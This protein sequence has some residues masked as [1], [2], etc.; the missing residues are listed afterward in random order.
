M[1]GW[2]RKVALVAAVTV[3][4]AALAIVAL[5]PSGDDPSS[6]RAPVAPHRGAVLDVRATA[7][8]IS[9]DGRRCVTL[10]RAGGTSLWSCADG[11]RLRAR[12]GPAGGTRA[13]V[14]YTRDGVAILTS[15]GAGATV[16]DPRD[17]AVVRRL[18]GPSR[19]LVPAISPSG[20]HALR[21]LSLHTAAIVDT[22]GGRRIAALRHIPDLGR[23]T[24]D[25]SG[26]D[27]AVAVITRPRS[28]ATVFDATDGEPLHSFALEHTSAD[29]DLSADG[30][31]LLI[32]DGTRVQIVDVL[33]GVERESFSPPGPVSTG[34]FGVNERFVVTGG[35]DGAVSVWDAETGSQVAEY[36]GGPGAVASATL[37]A[38]GRLLVAGRRASP[39]VL[40]CAACAHG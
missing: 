36:A 35:A 14:S 26:D 8:A 5:V 6:A 33:T 29:V 9:P 39:V 11:K 10:D 23:A 13:S 19:E 2:G 28:W 16:L 7:A 31:R 1:D 24:V 32:A 21:P 40:D 30:K 27:R 34:S 12:P 17:L 4:A 37:A 20:V 15:T 22:A 25:F 38:D 3:I 18:R